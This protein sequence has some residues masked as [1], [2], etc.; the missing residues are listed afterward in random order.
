MSEEL[1]VEQIIKIGMEYYEKARHIKGGGLLPAEDLYY[2][3]CNSL[4]KLLA[5]NKRLREAIQ[6]ALGLTMAKFPAMGRIVLEQAFT[7]KEQDSE[8]T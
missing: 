4:K 8:T 2:E 5:E 1:K 3:A 6:E 7:R